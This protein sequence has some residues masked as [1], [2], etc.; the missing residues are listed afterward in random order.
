DG[1]LA[2]IDGGPRHRAVLGHA[3]DGG[4][5]VIGWRRADPRAVFH[6]VPMSAATTGA[7]QQQR[8]RDLGYDVARA[9]PM[10][11]IDT[12]ADLS[13]VTRAAPHLSTSRLARRLLPGVSP[14]SPGAHRPLPD[15]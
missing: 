6:G 10:R 13:A 2:D 4:W 7:A 5:W 9:R 14:V 8:L 1:L 12:V 15:G 11:D 3:V